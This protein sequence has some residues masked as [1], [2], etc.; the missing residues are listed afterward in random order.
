M[1]K[2]A[3]CVVSYLRLSESEIIG[4]NLHEY[5]K[6]LAFDML[7]QVFSDF[8]CMELKEEDIKRTAFGKP[9]YAGNG[10][11]YFNIS[12]CKTAVVIAVSEYPVGIDVE[13]MRQVKHHM[14]RKCCSTKEI[15]YVM[16][17]KD[18]GRERKSG[19]SEDETRRFLQMWTLKES[20]VKMTGEGLRMPI[21]T[22]SFEPEHFQ[23]RKDI[24]ICKK[25]W[26][27]NSSSYL[28][29]PKELTIALTMQSNVL[30]EEQIIWKEYIL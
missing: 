9:Y 6:R 16:E 26:G 13:S 3:V 10:N 30:K 12:H 19:L 17:R 5:Q 27:K 22:I 24:L 21:N 1:R 28:Y 20:Y 18:D 23:K 2:E 11:F 8:L 15:Q 4:K 14:V 29:F 7:K 25:E